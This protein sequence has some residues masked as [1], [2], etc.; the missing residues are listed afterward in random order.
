MNSKENPRKE[1]P[2][3]NDSEKIDFKRFSE[4]R[5][6][7]KK[8]NVFKVLFKKNKAFD[9]ASDADERPTLDV[10]AKKISERFS[11]AHNILWIVLILFVVTYFAFFSDSI[12]TG[13]MQHMFRNMLGHGD[14]LG[15]S[16]KYGFSVN[17]NAVFAEFSG[18]P[19]MAGSDRV[20]IF[21]PDGSHQY[22]DESPYALPEIKVSDKYIL[23]YD[24]SGNSFGIYDAFGT[25]YTENSGG[26]IYSAALADN[27]TYVVGRKGN[28]YNSEI[29]IYTSNFELVNLIK[30]NN[31]V[32]SL[33]I[34]KDG[35]EIMLL[36]YSVSPEGDVESELMLLETRSDSPRKLFTLNEGMPLECKYLADG[37]IVLLFDDTISVLDGDGKQ[38]ASM[39]I[40]IA[41]SYIYALSERGELGYFSRGYVDSDKLTFHMLRLDEN[42]VKRSQHDVSGKVTRLNMYSDFAYII[43][44]NK[45]I[46]ISTGDT[47]DV[48]Y[49]VSERKMYSLVRISGKEYIAFSDALEKIEFEN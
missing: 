11:L 39:A 8:Q 40:D 24:R 38:I 2:S 16:D 42:G 27:G 18:V 22:S 19:V 23:I 41:S 10:E 32:A 48:S 12:T 1:D 21:A 3:F 28:E 9:S 6:K 7:Q 14:A 26:K 44:E 49:F 45:A 34:K 37:R 4:N 47:G 30:K 35:S 25:R 5:E 43:T 15:S 13:S 20:V 29:S 33:D 17:D 36:T 31:R 46:R